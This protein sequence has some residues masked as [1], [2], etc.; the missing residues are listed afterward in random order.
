LK[1]RMP[2]R[3]V[4][5]LTRRVLPWAQTKERNKRLGGGGY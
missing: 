4:F 3:L 1:R 5:K 2:R